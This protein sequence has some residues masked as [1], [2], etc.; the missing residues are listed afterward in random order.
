LLNVLYCLFFKSESGSFENFHEMWIALANSDLWK[1]LAI[2]TVSMGVL[3]AVIPALLSFVPFLKKPRV[4]AFLTRLGLFCAGLVV[5]LLG[6]GLF[7]FLRAIANI[8]NLVTINEVPV[9]G[10]H[11]LIA[12]A[13]ILIGITFFLLNIN[14]TGPHRLYRDRLARTFIANDSHPDPR[15]YLEEMNAT[16]LAP[17]HLLNTTVNLPTSKNSGVRDR[18]ADF[19]LFSKH[20]TGS[21]L[22]GFH[23][24]ADWKTNNRPPDLATAMATSGAA[25][26]SH[27]GLTSRP[28]LRALLTFLNIRLGFWIRQPEEPASPNF[29]KSPRP[30][31]TCLLREMTGTFMDEKKS[32]INLSDGGHIENL[33][34]YELLRRR[35]KFI[36]CIDGEADPEFTFHGLM[37]LTRHAQLDFGIRLDSSLDDI[38][39]NPETKVSRS[40]YRLSRIHYPAIPEAGLSAA[41]GLFLYLKLSV[42]GNESELIRRYRHNNPN[43]PHQ[44]TLDQFFDQEQFESYRQL[45]A[46]AA[47]GLFADSLM[48]HQEPQSIEEWFRSLADNLLEP[49]V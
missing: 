48:N 17:V 33:A 16:G 3:A 21:V 20:W 10:L 28:A 14:L 44:T 24:T 13:V 34:V 49:A 8:K 39:P 30:G 40:H 6:L 46:H 42:T 38:R 26:S 35:T 5:P 12:L 37:T 18:R 23:K 36:I 41:T 31:F 27:M 19:F 32:W 1:G 29:L 4:L 2:P 11:F 7:L 43:F 15:P 22:T 9:P 47:E 25:F 45:G